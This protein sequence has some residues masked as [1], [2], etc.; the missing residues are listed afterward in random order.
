MLVTWL[1]IWELKYSDNFSEFLGS[2]SDWSHFLSRLFRS[3]SENLVLKYASAVLWEEWIET[4]WNTLM[5]PQWIFVNMDFCASMYGKSSSQS[6][7]SIPNDVMTDLWLSSTSDTEKCVKLYA[8]FPT[9]ELSPSSAAKM[10]T[11]ADKCIVVRCF[12]C[13]DYGKILMETGTFSGKIMVTVNGLVSGV[14]RVH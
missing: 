1:T 3:T 2:T 12:V 4:W 13:G 14:D 8:G 5:N 6:L 9:S 7:V 11:L 10:L